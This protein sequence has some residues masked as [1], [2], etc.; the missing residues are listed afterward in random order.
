MFSIVIPTLNN[1]K[2]LK[3]CI[4]SIIK[5][6]KMN[7]EI[8]VHVSEDYNKTTRDFLHKKNIDFTYTEQ[9]VGLC[10]AINIIAK[11]AKFPNLIYA[12]DDMYF[13]PKWEKPL[14]SEIERIKHNKY[15][16]SGSMIE[17]NSGHIKF[18]C[19]ANLEEF[20]EQKLLKNLDNLKIDDHQ[21]SH[22]APHCVH[23]DLWNKV[24]GFSEE[25]NPGIASDPDFN[26]KLWSEGVR[27]FKGLG[28]FKV[29]HFGSIT[30]RKNK[31]VK[32]NRGDNTFLKKWGYS[33]N[34]FK[35]HYLRSNTK[36][37]SPLEEPKKNIIYYLELLK[38]KLK[39]LY[40]SLIS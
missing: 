16:I 36:Y 39:L 11:K 24:G 40:I 29:Y 13:C 17:Q 37:I 15:Y 22:F 32:Q 3:F 30:T 35:K 6:S 14:Q 8:L 5:N 20:D 2:Y 12:H 10:T 7:N 9:N 1:L 19:G 18:D 31:N 33:T 27:I 34:F 23:V 38:N 26:M 4:N 28:E 25:F 21:G